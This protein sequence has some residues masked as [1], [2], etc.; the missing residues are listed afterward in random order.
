MSLI[1]GMTLSSIRSSLLIIT[2]ILWQKEAWELIQIHPYQ[3]HCSQYYHNNKFNGKRIWK[4]FWHTKKN[5]F[6]KS[7]AMNTGTKN[8]D[9]SFSMAPNNGHF[10]HEIFFSFF[11]RQNCS[12]MNKF[13]KQ[14]GLIKSFKISSLHKPIPRKNQTT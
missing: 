14:I 5:H 3:H 6:C 13:R 10:F 11:S 8:M 1:C 9:S 7:N 4:Y 2:I 12:M